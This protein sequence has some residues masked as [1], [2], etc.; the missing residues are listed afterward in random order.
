MTSSNP[1]PLETALRRLLHDRDRPRA[2][3]RSV[4]AS[5]A[6]RG[7]PARP[8]SSVVQRELDWFRRGQA[9]PYWHHDRHSD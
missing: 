1:K 8:S 2:A 5:R 9:L 3:T 4:R 6:A 7:A